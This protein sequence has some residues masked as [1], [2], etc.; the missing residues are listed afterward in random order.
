MKLNLIHNLVTLNC[1][2]DGAFIEEDIFNIVC[3]HFPKDLYYCRISA[4]KISSTAWMNTIT[5]TSLLHRYFRT[6]VELYSC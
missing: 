1:I 4:N 2:E 5:Q 6:I 3:I